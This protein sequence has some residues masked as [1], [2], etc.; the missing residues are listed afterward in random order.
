MQNS[1]TII[2]QCTP[3]GSGAIALLRISGPQAIIVA[4]AIAQLPQNKKLIDQ[5]S[6]TIHYGFIVDIQGQKIDQVLFLLMHAP[7]TFTGEHTVEITCHNNPFIIQNIIDRACS[8]GARLAYNGEFCRQAIEN[9]KLDLIQAE[10]INELIHAHTQAAL[11]NALGQVTGTLSAIIMKCE[12]LLIKAL[13]FSEASF[14]FIDEELGFIENIKELINTV[15][16]IITDLKLSFDNQQ[17]I[18]NGI[19]IALIGSV[20]AG[21]SSLFNAL[22][23]Q[24]RAIVTDIAGTTRDSI[25]AGRYTESDYQTIVDTAGLRQTDDIVEQKGIERSFEQAH[26]ADIIILV[27]DGSRMLSNQE[28]D[29]YQSIIDQ[30]DSK[31]IPVRSKN[32]LPVIAPSSIHTS[33]TNAIAISVSEQNSIDNLEL[34]LRSK[35]DTLLKKGESSFLLNQRH[36]HLICTLEKHLAET[37][38]LLIEPVHYE[39][40]S[41]HLQEALTALSGLTGKSVS[42]QGMDAVFKEFCVGK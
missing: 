23:K 26:L 2:A 38:S 30:Y 29:V 13:A 18:K 5:V 8:V 39:L 24:N 15:Q 31:I 6:H 28:H 14:E 25:E 10:A 4:D 3:S 34:A 17:H 21:K 22:L 36:Y 40:I 37:Q 32:D 35:I 16:K 9:D 42:E 27:F 33:L 7:H 12:K 19:R 41:Y 11:K 20:N 1:P